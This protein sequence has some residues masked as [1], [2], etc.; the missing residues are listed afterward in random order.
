MS[1][2]TK[3]YDAG[4][5]SLLELIRVMSE[6]AGAPFAAGALVKTGL[7]IARR[8]EAME[9]PTFQAFLQ[10]VEAGA[11]IVAKFEG[12][13]RYYGDGIFGLP[14]CPFAESV[15]TYQEYGG[16]L[17]AEYS[18]VTV[19]LNRPSATSDKLRVGHGA[20]VSPFCGVHQ[21]IRSALAEKI[22]V[23][24]KPVVVYQLGCKSGAGR[25]SVAEHFL[26]QAG[27]DRQLVDQ[28]LDENMCCYCARAE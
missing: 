16:T 12:A 18:A 4:H 2:V 26:Q 25:R 19:S 10:S 17:P 1:N 22:R 7:G 15:R 13:A 23:G 21:P 6:I 8:A 9:F 5:L 14:V 20:S 28:V 24:G 27:V 3:E 11:N